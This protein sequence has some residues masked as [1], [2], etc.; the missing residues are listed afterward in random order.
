MKKLLALWTVTIVMVSCNT[1]SADNTKVLSASS[2]S[3]EYKAFAK[4]KQ[5]K[6]DAAKKGNTAIYKEAP[7]AGSTTSTTDATPKKKGW[8]K[9]AKGAVIGGVAGATAGAIIN[10]RAPAVGAV[11]GGVIGAG[12]GYEI[13]KSKDKKDGRN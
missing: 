4:W 3:A 8:S 7:G 10:K 12:A 9:A 11:V 6:E 2:D 13:G 5:A 1:K